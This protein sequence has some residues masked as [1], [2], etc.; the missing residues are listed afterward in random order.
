MKHDVII[1]GAG[2]AGLFA[3]E[4]II[5]S[6]KKLSVLVID[7]GKD[8]PERKC[9]TYRKDNSCSIC[10]PCN[11]SFGV[12]GAGGLSDGKLNLHHKIGM[13][14]EELDIK[15]ERAHKLIEYIDALFLKFGADKKLYGTSSKEIEQLMKRTEKVNQIIK[16]SSRKNSNGNKKAGVSLI[17]NIVRHMGSDNTPKIIA[18]FKKG[19]EKKGVIFELNTEIEKIIANKGF[20]LISGNKVYESTYLIVAP[21]RAMSY[22]FREE[23]TRLG[24]VHNFGEIDVGVR[25][26][27]LAKDYSEVTDLIY[28]PKF[29]IYTPSYGD[30]VRTFCTNPG[31]EVTSEQSSS[32]ILVNGHAKSNEKTKNTNFALL[33]TIDLTGPQADTTHY[34]INIAK[35]VNFISGEK[36][37]IQTLGDL[38]NGHRSTKEK[39][40]KNKVKPT[41]KGCNP[42]D[43]GMALNYRITKNILETLD[44]LDKIVPGVAKDST[45]I[46]APEIKFYDTKY[47]TTRDLETNIKNLFVAGDGVGKSRGIVGAALTGIIAAEG[48]LKKAR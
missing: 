13:N 47:T 40:A 9:P 4:K 43:I 30:K 42:G 6:N 41:L 14:I 29:H 32:M 8:V 48:I 45:L 39:I 33:C 27:L 31:G 26:E 25:I 2:P 23:A 18:N 46:Y 3:A 11:I 16:E 20:H 34:G 17:P 22:W 1:I 24:I 36:P 44:I 37:L 19:L 7:K 38:K 12:G 35:F 21:G 5:N 15:K 28:C 10:T